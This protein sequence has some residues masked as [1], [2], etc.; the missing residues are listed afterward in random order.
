MHPTGPLVAYLRALRGRIGSSSGPLE[1]AR[2]RSFGLPYG[3]PG[4]HATSDLDRRAQIFLDRLSAVVEDLGPRDREV[5]RQFFFGSGSVEDR[6]RAIVKALESSPSTARN[7]QREALARVAT[8]LLEVGEESETEARRPE[9]LAGVVDAISPS[10]PDSAAL[11][12]LASIILP[13]RPVIED[14][15]ITL[16]M[17]DAGKPDHYNLLI[18]STTSARPGRL[19]LALTS[20]ASLSDLVVTL[21]PEVT[22]VFTCSTRE[23]VQRRAKEWTEEDRVLLTAAGKDSRGL[24]TRLSLPLALLS[25]QD[26]AEVL[27]DLP[28]SDVE[29]MAVLAADVPDI[30]GGAGLMPVE[31]KLPS[32]MERR[33]HYCYWLA[34]RPTYVRRIAVEWSGLTLP[35]EQKVRLRSTIR[36]TAYEPDYDESGC[37]FHVDGWLVAGQGVIVTWG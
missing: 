30:S 2:V 16:T 4:D 26:K 20:R 23:D 6:D 14:A 21:C 24:T 7:S 12:Q 15:E 10:Y 19:Y 35:E 27:G 32:V 8:R 37:I 22:E 29:G 18:T 25:E 3:L 31:I 28:A 34:D 9:L 33:D 11:D 5:A 36:T 17:R 13:N 1:V